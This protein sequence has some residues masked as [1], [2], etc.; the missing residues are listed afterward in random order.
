MLMSG[1][2]SVGTDRLCVALSCQSQQKNMGIQRK[3]RMAVPAA[4]PASN[5]SAKCSKT[6]SN[7]SL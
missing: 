1:S 4:M 7:G 6:P 2:Q 3:D 5:P